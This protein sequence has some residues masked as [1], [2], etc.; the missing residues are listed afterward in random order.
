MSAG[1]VTAARPAIQQA[2]GGASPR[3]ALHNMI[4]TSVACRVAKVFIVN[5]HYLHTFPGA[6]AMAFGV[7]LGGRLLGA[8]TL[9]AGP[10]NA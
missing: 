10:A 7:L 6:T 8:L 4:V 2:G 3:T 5:H 9:G 1:G